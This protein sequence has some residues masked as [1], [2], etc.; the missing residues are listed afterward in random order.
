MKTRSSLTVA[1]VIIL[2]LV[3]TALRSSAADGPVPTL[4]WLH[5]G[6]VLTFT[7]Y[8][9]VAAGNGSNYEEDGHGGWIDPR[10]GRH[11]SRSDQRGTSGSGW[12][13][14]TIACIDGEKVVLS[15]SSFANAG[16]LGNNQPVPQQ[17]GQQRGSNSG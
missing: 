10:T 3:G 11:L 1:V 4:P 13:Q 8:A 5:E 16:A 6:L 7:W 17:G 15:L 2:A 12:N 9:A 14:I